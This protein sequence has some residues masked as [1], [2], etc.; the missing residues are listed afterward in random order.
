MQCCAVLTVAASPDAIESLPDEWPTQRDVDASPDEA[1]RYEQAV[2][3]LRELNDRRVELRR[4]VEK[5]RMMQ[6]AVRSLQ[7]TDAVQRNLVSSDG[8]VE[9]ELERM[10][11]LLARVAGRVAA[12]PD[13][14]HD[15]VNLGELAGAGKSRVDGF[16][17]DPNV[18][19]T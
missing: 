13:T 5:L 7:N 6:N 2:A 1:A 8:E 14:E 4:R 16:L 10:R 11:G 15:N 9:R 12:L 3:A 17:A 18:F 19:P